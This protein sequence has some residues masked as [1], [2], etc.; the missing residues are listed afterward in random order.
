MTEIVLAV[1]EDGADD[2]RL[3]DLGRLLREELLQLPEAESVDALV[4]GEAPPGTRGGLVAE[5]G[6]L[7]VTAQPHVAA[8]VAIVGSVWK[9]LRRAGS[10][11]PRTIRIEVDGDVLE[12]SGATNELQDK[13]VDD[14]I[15]RRS[16]ST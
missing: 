5:A 16:A 11:T 1:S 8:V 12:L 2:V 15:A 14:W 4:V 7:V 9:W 13:L 6:A 3:D 10:G